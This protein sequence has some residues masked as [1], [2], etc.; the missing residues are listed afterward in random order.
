MFVVTFVVMGDVVASDVDWSEV[1][2]LV[3]LYEIDALGVNEVLDAFAVV[4]T[5]NDDGYILVVVWDIV[6]TIDGVS[7]DLD[8]KTVDLVFLVVNG[9]VIE[10]VCAVSVNHVEVDVTSV[11]KATDVDFVVVVSNIVV[12]GNIVVGDTI[13]DV[14]V[15]GIVVGD[16]VSAVDVNSVVKS[17]DVGFMADT[18]VFVDNVVVCEVN[19]SAVVK[20]TE[21]FNGSDVV[22]IGKVVVINDVLDFDWVVADKVDVGDIVVDDS[23]NCFC[24]L[25]FVTV[26]IVIVSVVGIESVLEVVL[27]DICKVD[28]VVNAVVVDIVGVVDEVVTID[29]LVVFIVVEIGAKLEMSVA[30]CGVVLDSTEL[31][32]IM[33]LDSIFASV[34]PAIAGR[35]V[36]SSIVLWG[37]VFV[38]AD[39]WAVVVSIDVVSAVALKVALVASVVLDMS[40]TSCLVLCSTDVVLATVGACVKM[41]TFLCVLRWLWFLV[42][43]LVSSKSTEKTLKSCIII[44]IS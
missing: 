26:N 42:W 6:V 4:V 28:S 17:T 16:F 12:V 22:V 2:V 9:F 29:D 32:P 14:I 13:V 41:S 15:D 7:G 40:S 43:V 36:V 39:A 23:V 8:D 38:V 33:V 19:F 44:N 31:L 35:E 27:V 24:V 25:S 30:V 11:V 5:I 21:V 34:K 37:C 20:G 3:V 1:K 10:V 18:D